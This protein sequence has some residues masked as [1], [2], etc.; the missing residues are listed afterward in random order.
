VSEMTQGF[1]ILVCM[2]VLVRMYVFLW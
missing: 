1:L 2:I